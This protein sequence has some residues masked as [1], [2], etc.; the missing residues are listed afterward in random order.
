VKIL[1]TIAAILF[2]ILFNTL[3]VEAQEIIKP[4]I[5]YYKENGDSVYLKD[6]IIYLKN[7]AD[8]YNALAGINIIY[9]ITYRIPIDKVGMIFKKPD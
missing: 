3:K 4:L 8:I 9:G 2:F 1:L 6:S 7:D 5:K